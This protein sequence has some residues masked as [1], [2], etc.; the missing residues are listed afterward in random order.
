MQDLI[1]SDRFEKYQKFSKNSLIANDKNLIF[2]STPD[3]ETILDIQV[4]IKCKKCGLKTC[5]NCRQ[6]YHGSVSCEDNFSKKYENWTNSGVVV[7]KCPKCDC[8]IEKNGGCPQMNCDIC[9]HEWCWTC[10]LP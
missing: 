8:Q 10:G 4:S 2:C 3:C 6:A 5:K 9:G 1:S 7:N